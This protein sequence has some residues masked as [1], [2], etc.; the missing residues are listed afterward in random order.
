MDSLGNTLKTQTMADET[1]REIPPDR[2]DAGEGRARLPESY[3]QPAPAQASRRALRLD[4]LLPS[5]GLVLT[6][7]YLL[8]LAGIAYLAMTGASY[9]LSPLVERPRHPDYWIFKPG[10]RLGL[11][12][13]MTGTGAMLVMHLYSLRKRWRFLRRLGGLRAWLD[14]H[15]LLG[16]VGPLL[17]VLHTS[18][19]FRGI[20]SVSFWSM[21]IVAASGFVGRFLYLQL[22]R[23]SRGHELSLS[24]A[25]SE[26]AAVFERL[27]RD[28][29][30]VPEEI[31]TPKV[32]SEVGTFQSLLRVLMEPFVLR[33]RTLLHRRGTWRSFPPGMRRELARVVLHEASLRRRLVLWDRLHELFHYWHVF[34]RPFALLLYLFLAVHVAV[35]WSTGYAGGWWR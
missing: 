5:R 6:V 19:K 12:Y 15:I 8:A 30:V 33:V 26:H 11:I 9:Y 32:E 10:G 4:S 2:T 25:E 3:P 27:K 1:S 28:F 24:E 13:A 17:I 35:A 16:I 7:L 31:V 14:A 23:S 18:F 29:G 34:H 22:P 21:V 20:V